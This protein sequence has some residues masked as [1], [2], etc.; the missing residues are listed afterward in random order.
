MPKSPK[1]TEVCR[2]SITAEKD[3]QHSGEGRRGHDEPLGEQL[4]SVQ[5]IGGHR[6]NLRF[7][8]PVVCHGRHSSPG[9]VLTVQVLESKPDDQA[10][11][12]RREGKAK[13]SKKTMRSRRVV[14]DNTPRDTAGSHRGQATTVL[15]L[16]KP[17]PWR[18]AGGAVQP[19][20]S[21]QACLL[22]TSP[23]PR[24]ATLSRMPSSA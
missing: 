10:Y 11:D 16:Y 23:S 18:N 3:V 5:P 19:P 14:F 12:T 13:P 24:D 8:S 22:Y 17:Q 2:R 7:E 9:H 1:N 4:R 15:K 6:S 20:A 21:N